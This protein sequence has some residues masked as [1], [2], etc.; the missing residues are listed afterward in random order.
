MKNRIIYILI[1]LLPVSVLAQTDSLKIAR[2]L[3]K[4]FQLRN[5]NHDSCKI[6]IDNAG[7]ILANSKTLTNTSSKYLN[8]Y[9]Y[10]RLADYYSKKGSVNLSLDLNIKALNFIQNNADISSLKLK[11]RIFNNI[12]IAHINKSEF[13]K[14]L[15]YYNKALKIEEKYGKPEDISA[16][17]C[18]IGNIYFEIMDLSKALFYFNKAKEID[19]KINNIY[20]LAIVMGNLGSLYLDSL[21][22]NKEVLSDSISKKLFI[23]AESSFNEAYLLY[24]KQKYADGVALMLSSISSLYESK[25]DLKSAYQ[26]LYKAL[27]IVEELEDKINIAYILNDISELLINEKKYS[28][29]IIKLK[30][31]YSLAK[32]TSSLDL[33][34]T[35]NRSL[36][37]VYKE[38]AQPLHDIET[39]KTLS[40]EAMR[41]KS[42]DFLD[43]YYQLK[44]S[45]FR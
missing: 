22:F 13:D 45:V 24:E 31:A 9:Y 42:I 29:A 23:Q 10:Y 28:D 33:L 5:S 21:N 16:M 7:E 1:L 35:L 20:N 4:S 12:G 6:F 15:E 18:N 30:K 11:A 38:S 40:I 41:I 26:Y 14:S 3:E 44:D 27:K 39:N 8:A 34:M 17:Y 36:H 19:S 43:K 2:F 25:G 37:Q 32:E